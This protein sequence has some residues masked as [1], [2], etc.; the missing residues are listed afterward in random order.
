MHNSKN[1]SPVG[2]KVYKNVGQPCTYA[3]WS[4]LVDLFSICKVLA[5]DLVNEF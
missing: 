3:P 2:L 1:I 5:L 4:L